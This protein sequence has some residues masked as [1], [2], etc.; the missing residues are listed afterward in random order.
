LQDK[1]KFQSEL[2]PSL[3]SGLLLDLHLVVLVTLLA[4]HVH[5]KA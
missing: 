5:I 3:T 2:V 1:I 4:I